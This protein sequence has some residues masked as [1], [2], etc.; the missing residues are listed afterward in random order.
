[1]NSRT[2]Y[3]HIPFVNVPVEKWA[4][5]VAIFSNVLV[6]N[7]LYAQE[8]DRQWIILDGPVD[9]VWQESMNTTL[10]D[11]KKLCLTSGEIIQM[12]D[13]MSLVF[14]VRIVAVINRFNL[15]KFFAL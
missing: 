8:G 15:F 3:C 7:A 6:C 11:T 10:D 14:E 2:A 4:R 13:K 12:T 5:F 1:M 9:P